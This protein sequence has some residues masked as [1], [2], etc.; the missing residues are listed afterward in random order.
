M[1]NVSESIDI[2]EVVVSPIE[3]RFSAGTKPLRNSSGSSLK[4]EI[5]EV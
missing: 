5:N 3:V 1:W 2:E 4:S